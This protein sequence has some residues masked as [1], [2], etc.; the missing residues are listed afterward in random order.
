MLGSL[1][2]YPVGSRFRDLGCL[3]HGLLLALI[4]NLVSLGY[5]SWLLVCLDG[6]LLIPQALDVDQGLLHIIVKSSLAGADV[7]EGRLSVRIPAHQA[8]YRLL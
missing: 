6:D 5:S 8:R 7:S 1:L 3:E 2:H 4:P